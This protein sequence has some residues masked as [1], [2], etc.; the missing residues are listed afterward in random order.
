[1]ILLNDSSYAN[2]GFEMITA[3]AH[4]GYGYPPPIDRSSGDYADFERQNDNQAAPT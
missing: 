4:G 1:M 3:I 2:R